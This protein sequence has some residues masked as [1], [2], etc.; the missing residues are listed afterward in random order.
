MGH[1]MMDDNDEATLNDKPQLGGMQSEQNNEISDANGDLA[2]AIELLQPGKPLILYDGLIITDGGH[3]IMSQY[4]D[5]GVD[6]MYRRPAYLLKAIEAKYGLEHYND[7]QLSAPYRF[8][9]YGETL[10]RDVQEGH[11]RREMKTE[12]PP[13]S[14]EEKNREQERALCNLGHEGVSIKNTGTT[15]VHTDT[16]SMTF[17]RNSWIYCT[18]MPETHDKKSECRT[19]LPDSYDHESVIRQPSKF[20]LALGAMFAD[21]VGPQGKQ[22]HFT[23][24]GEIRSFHDSQLVYHGPVWYTNDVLGFLESRQSEPLYNMYPLFVKH[25]D[26]RE[27]REYR[28][29]FHCNESIKA[30]TLHLHISRAIRDTLAPL[31]TIGPVTFQQLN[32]SDTNS[33]S[34]KV[35]GPTP[36]NQTMTRTRMKSQRHRR[37]LKIGGEL[38]QEEVITSEETIRLTTEL[39]VDGPK[40]AKIEQEAATHGVGEF[41]ESENRER[42]IAGAGVDTMTM[43]RTRV[44]SIAD[45]LD[46][47]D[48]FSFEDRDE[49]ESFLKAVEKPFAAFSTLPHG[50]TEA[51]RTLAHQA[52]HLEPKFEVQTMS[53][54]W[55]GIWAICNLY[56][57]FGDVV[58]S[59][60][61]EHNEFVAI[62]LK[63]S[64]HTGAEGKILVGPRGTFAYMLTRSDQQL[65]GYGGVEDRLFFFPDEEARA[66]FEE[67]GWPP[68]SE[69]SASNGPADN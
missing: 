60:D 45:T 52:S 16:E 42:R 27:L 18:S 5:I 41:A 58:A 33:S 9:D 6:K 1:E 19:N 64:A 32:T 20:A 26:Y 39:P 22:G 55:N 28:F 14:T 7:I 48:L 50:A 65:P 69:Q 25:S 47:D 11:A 4:V 37:T 35:V 68:L 23:H 57:C 40:N 54:C 12:N 10:I 24:D 17:G 13:P 53:A 59:V 36:T 29:V 21:Q 63:E 51:L 31:R 67:F 15:S 44:F 2:A 30:T 62:T 56:E 38:A 8:R 3:L 46:T 34:Q 49:A 61:I 43:S 66:A